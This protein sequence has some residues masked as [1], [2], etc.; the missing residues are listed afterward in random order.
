M[1]YTDLSKEEQ[2]IADIIDDFFMINK[3]I[4]R[5]SFVRV[6]GFL[7]NKYKIKKVD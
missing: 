1:N 6:L 5:K 3:S 7:I 2:K 4:K